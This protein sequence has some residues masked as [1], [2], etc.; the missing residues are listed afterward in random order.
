M[1][2]RVIRFDVTSVDVDAVWKLA[3]TTL[4]YGKE[5]GIKTFASQI[6]RTVPITCSSWAL[7]EAV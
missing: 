6:G 7:G 5:E 4:L 1:E 3:D 2:I